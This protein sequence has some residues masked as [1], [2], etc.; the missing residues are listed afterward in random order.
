MFVATN[1][2]AQEEWELISHALTGYRLHAVASLG[3]DT[4]LTVADGST[5][6]RSTDLGATW[7][8]MS[9]PIRLKLRQ[10]VVVDSATVVVRSMEHELLGST[11]N[12]I[13]WTHLPR[14]TP[15]MLTQILSNGNGMLYA[16][17]VGPYF[18]RSQNGGLSWDSVRI[19][20]S[21]DAFSGS[22]D[23]EGSI[24]SVASDSRMFLMSSDSGVT[25]TGGYV[26]DIERDRS[27]TFDA[28][29]SATPGSITLVNTR[30]RSLVS[31]DQGKSWAMGDSAYGY[32]KQLFA[33]EGSL[34]LS[35]NQMQLLKS[36]DAGLTWTLFAP[37]FA[38]GAMAILKNAIVIA[39]D[40][41]ESGI[42]TDQGATWSSINPSYL[43]ANETFTGI[44]FFNK[45]TGYVWSS[46][47]VHKTRDG[48]KTWVSNDGGSASRLAPISEDEVLRSGYQIILRSK[49]GGA[50][51]TDTSRL[52]ENFE[53]W[54]LHPFSSNHWVFAG[55]ATNVNGRP[56]IGTSFDGG[57]TWI[58]KAWNH[59]ADYLIPFMTALPDSLHGILLSR[60]SCPYWTSNGGQ[61]W[62]L[63]EC[64]YTGG[65]AGVYALDSAHAWLTREAGLPL[66]ST[67][68]GRTWHT[69]IEDSTTGSTT[70]VFANDTLGFM[71][72]ATGYSKTVDGGKTWT[73]TL[74]DVCGDPQVTVTR[75]AIYA[76]AGKMV[77]ALYTADSLLAADPK[78]TVESGPSFSI[79]PNP[80]SGVARVALYSA[81]ASIISVQLIDYLGNQ[82]V[83][84]TPLTLSGNRIDVDCSSIS[85]GSYFLRVNSTK[86]TTVE[87]LL[88]IR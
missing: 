76:T 81:N 22:I 32:I 60:T 61:T 40:P 42:S 27:E 70:I 83:E 34:Y 64:S 88:I 48:G 7:L 38:N 57:A 67:D 36:T 66:S 46:K 13:T 45:M 29:A 15:G 73:H 71:F 14:P 23:A 1:A 80:S 31:T 74:S 50:T 84:Y 21:A 72:D 8:R 4:L 28:V 43:P 59:S 25:W 55:R 39:D 65:F 44:R 20:G 52:P 87:M 41:D 24:L 18:L 11:D 63:S 53:S 58:T 47:R 16:F 85:I 26:P 12:G 35:T 5:I 82:V 68:G 6:L 79:Y 54:S 56:Y 9:T 86:G 10:I 51:W 49:D 2:A 3:G 62:T 77:F 30:G 17:T 75:G 69:F 33:F 19:F 78:E 37:L